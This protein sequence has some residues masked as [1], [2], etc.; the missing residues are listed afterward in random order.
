MDYKQYIERMKKYI[1]TKVYYNNVLHTIVG[2]DY[3]GAALIDLPTRF[4]ETTAVS[5]CDLQYAWSKN[6]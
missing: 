4:N 5:F 2:V 6:I 3:N 1:G